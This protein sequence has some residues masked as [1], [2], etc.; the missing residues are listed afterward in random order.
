[1]R[2]VVASLGF[3]GR[4]RVFAGGLT[5]GFFGASGLLLGTGFAVLEVLYGEM[6]V[7][8]PGG[9]VVFISIFYAVALYSL[10]DFAVDFATPI[11]VGAVRVATCVVVCGIIAFYMASYAVAGD[12]FALGFQILA[13]AVVV[14]L[15]LLTR[16]W[17]RKAQS[18]SN[19]APPRSSRS[20]DR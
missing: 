20:R 12:I 2:G 19:G 6:T 13:P 7:S 1:M 16:W 14:V 10:S 18:R 11:L 9:P 8:P 17:I 15:I 5:A 4:R 3:S